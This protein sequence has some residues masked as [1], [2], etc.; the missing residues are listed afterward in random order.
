LPQRK[1]CRTLVANKFLY[2]IMSVK[3][4]WLDVTLMVGSVSYGSHFGSIMYLLNLMCLHS[5]FS[6]ALLMHCF[7]GRSFENYVSP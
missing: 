1:E 4:I 2:G 3:N 7:C 5:G 6:I